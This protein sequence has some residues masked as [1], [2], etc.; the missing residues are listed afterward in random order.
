VA[1][2]IEVELQP[3]RQPELELKLLCDLGVAAAARQLGNQP[4]LEL[5][6]S[7]GH[8]I[9]PRLPEPPLRRP[10]RLLV[11]GLKS[12]RN[13]PTVPPSLRQT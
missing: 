6:V 3:V 4:V 9:D 8:D 12:F 1:D 11:S 5:D 10:P 13:F 2:D 7:L